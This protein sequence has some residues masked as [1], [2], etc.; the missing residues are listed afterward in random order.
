MRPLLLTPFPLSEKIGFMTGAIKDAKSWWLPRHDTAWYLGFTSYT[1]MA[2][3][4]HHLP[5]LPCFW[6]MPIC[7]SPTYHGIKEKMRNSSRACL[8]YLPGSPALGIRGVVLTCEK[9]F[10]PRAWKEEQC[11]AGGKYLN[12][13]SGWKVRV[14]KWYHKQSLSLC[15]RPHMWELK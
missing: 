11:T 14:Y 10:S 15:A 2:S 9:W 3:L 1:V 6:W 8:Q 12:R 7:V 13:G 4:I 5:S